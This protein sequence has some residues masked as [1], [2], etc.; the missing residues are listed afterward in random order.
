MKPP[1]QISWPFSMS[2]RTAISSAR[3]AGADARRCACRGLATR[4]RRR[5]CARRP[6][7]A[8]ARARVVAGHAAALVVGVAMASAVGEDRRALGHEG[9]DALVVVVR[10]AERALHVGL[11]AERRRRGRAAATASSACRVATSARVGSAAR[12]AR[13]RLDLGRRRRRR[14]RTSRSG[15]AGRRPRRRACRRASPGR[16]RWRGRPVAAAARC[17]RSRGSGRSSRTPG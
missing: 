16:A 17:R 8:S 13:E 4:D 14:R 15:R 5:T 6:L 7:A 10:G 9:G 12:R 2:S 1:W 11:E 3:R